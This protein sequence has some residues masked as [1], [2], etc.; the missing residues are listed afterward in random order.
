MFEIK[1]L[2]EITTDSKTFFSD[3]RRSKGNKNQEEDWLGLDMPGE[4]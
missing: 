1:V 3:T 4:A 2:R